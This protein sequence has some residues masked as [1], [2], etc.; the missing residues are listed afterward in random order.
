MRGVYH[1]ETWSCQLFCFAK[2]TFPGKPVFF[3][4]GF[5][6]RGG[7]QPCAIDNGSQMCC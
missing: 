4:G 7:V 2:V 6:E 5:V 3:C 1:R